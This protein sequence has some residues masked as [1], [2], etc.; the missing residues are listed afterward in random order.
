[1]RAGGYRSRGIYRKFFEFDDNRRSVLQGSEAVLVSISRLFGSLLFALFILVAAGLAGSWQ[2]RNHLLPQTA[3]EQIPNRV[4]DGAK[5]SAGTVRSLRLWTT[6]SQEAALLLSAVL[7]GLGLH[8]RYR[9]GREASKREEAEYEL[10]RERRALEKR[11]EARTRELR[12]EV[13]ERTRAEELNR[14]QKHVLEMLAQAGRHP[15]EDILCRLAETVAAQRRVWECAV[16]LVDSTSQTLCL[17][18]HSHLD[19]K[20]RRNLVR[21]GTDMADAPESRAHASAALYLV[22]KM[23]EVRRPWSEL[24][25]AY[26]IQA[27]WAMPIKADRSSEVIGTLTVYSRLQNTPKP[28]DLELMETAANL[29]V[30]VVEH[31]RIHAELV[32]HA[33]R[34]SLSGLPNRRSGERA[35]AAAIQEASL[36]QECV[37]VLWIDLD[38]FKRI[39]DQF[40]HE[41]GDIVL[42]TVSQRL[43]AHRAAGGGVARMG[44]D[45]FLVLVPGLS[46]P[47]TAEEIAH[48]LGDSIAQ[49]IQIGKATVSV[50]ASIGISLYPRDGSAMDI[51]QRNADVAMYRAKA[52]GSGTCI[53]APTMISDSKVALEIEAGLRQALE[54]DLFRLV[55]QPVYGASRNL[56]GFE[57]LLRFRHPSLGEVPPDRF[58]PLAE[59]TRLIEP[60]GQWVLERAIEQLK[61]WRDMGMPRVSMGVN[62]SARQFVRED[63]AQ[64]VA[65]VLTRIGVSAESLTLELTESAVMKDHVAVVRQMNLLRECGVQLAVDDFG[66]GHSS[67]SYLYKLPIDTLKIDRSFVERLNTAESTRPIVEA[68]I[69]MARHLNLSTVAEGVETAAQYRILQQAGCRMF[70]GYLFGR[71]ME[72]SDAQALLMRQGDGTSRD[73]DPETVD[74]ESAR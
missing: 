68:V 6:A 3:V 30:L 48:E 60:I 10:A 20:L 24:L 69:S 56:L 11:I 44:G 31:R 29:A 70:Q 40:G 16:H 47:T 14:G 61:V 45:E 2:L 62:I 32:D 53:Y 59:E 67:L 63:F 64:T 22:D 42:R 41:A 28:R 65:G 46:D 17:A 13:E 5:D 9:F 58:I 50:S 4:A 72:Q 57:A 51:L 43:R 25:V 66:T 23:T 12:L 38:R 8:M 15:T 34:D 71:P 55:F 35:I 7:C 19:E 54:K 37:G 18:G 26:G 21:I 36:R 73:A 33:Y 74:L 27:A 1:M 49:P 52:A 39:N